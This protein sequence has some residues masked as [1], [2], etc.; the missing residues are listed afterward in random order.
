M[1]YL[2]ARLPMYPSIAR[3]PKEIGGHFVG[4]SVSYSMR[5]L[6]RTC[7]NSIFLFWI[8]FI[9]FFILELGFFCVYVVLCFGVHFFRHGFPYHAKVLSVSE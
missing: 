6:E 2:P 8:S 4:F 3:E 9:I 7:K 1:A 5:N